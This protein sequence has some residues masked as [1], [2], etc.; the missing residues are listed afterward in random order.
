MT[1]SIYS[2]QK[3]C[4]HIV[5]LLLASGSSTLWAQTVIVLADTPYS[6]KE[7]NMLQGPNGILHRLINEASPSVVM[8]LGDFKSGGKSCTDDLLREHKSLLA[9]I[10]TGKLI[11][12]P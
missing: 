2:W 9:Q 12:T 6:A 7:K 8:H 5:F 10:Y 1:L 3:R 4:L 11:Y